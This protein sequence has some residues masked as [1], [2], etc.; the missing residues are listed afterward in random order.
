MY[1]ILTKEN[2]SWQLSIKILD[3]QKQAPKCQENPNLKI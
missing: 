2:K 3:A 1:R